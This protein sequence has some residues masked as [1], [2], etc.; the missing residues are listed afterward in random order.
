MDDVGECITHFLDML[1][2]NVM[3]LWVMSDYENTRKVK[4]RMKSHLRK[5]KGF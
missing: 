5:V 3:H 4:K 2:M 1:K